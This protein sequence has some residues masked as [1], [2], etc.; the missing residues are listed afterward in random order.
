LIA[1]VSI[2]SDHALNAGD[3]V[4]FQHGTKVVLAIV[5]S[6]VGKYDLNSINPISFNEELQLNDLGVVKIR[7]SQELPLDRYADLP[8][9]GS[10][11]LV[12]QFNGATIAAGMITAD[13]ELEPSI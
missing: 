5:E 8:R 10:F 2:L 12:N 1:N 7:L 11:L 4:Y 13:F 6:I 9:T 3:R